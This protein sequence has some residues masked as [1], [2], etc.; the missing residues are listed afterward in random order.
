MSKQEKIQVIAETT[1]NM[2]E[3]MV[4]DG[5]SSEAIAKFNQS[6]LEMIAKISKEV[7]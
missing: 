6:Q 3:Q 1:K 7:G 2:V 5:E 4:R